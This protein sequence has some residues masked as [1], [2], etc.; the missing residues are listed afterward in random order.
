MN[1]AT[2]AVARTPATK[3]VVCLPHRRAGERFSG[4]WTRLRGL[5]VEYEVQPSSGPADSVSDLGLGFSVARAALQLTMAPRC[6]VRGE[7]RHYPNRRLLSP[8][9][10]EM[11]SS[12]LQ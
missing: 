6:D 12:A 9:A 2:A 8:R 5:L 4:G 3:R 11:V 7:L 10:A 1:G